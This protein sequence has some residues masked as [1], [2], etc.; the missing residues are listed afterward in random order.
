MHNFTLESIES[1]LDVVKDELDYLTKY[2]NDEI[3]EIRV[4]LDPVDA[5]VIERVEEHKKQQKQ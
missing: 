3:K 2:M 1:K 5:R 4:K